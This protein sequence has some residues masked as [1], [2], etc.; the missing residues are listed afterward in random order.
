[1][2]IDL[3]SIKILIQHPKYRKKVQWWALTV[4]IIGLTLGLCF[5]FVV[6]PNY[7]KYKVSNAKFRLLTQKTKKLDQTKKQLNNNTKKVEENKQL[8]SHYNAL[9]EDYIKY[10]YKWFINDKKY[11][12]LKFTNIVYTHEVRLNKKERVLKRKEKKEFLK[13]RL[14]LDIIGSYE[15]I[16]RYINYINNLPILFNTELLSIKSEENSK[17]LTLSLIIQIYFVE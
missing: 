8:L 6:S 11:Q 2:N 5:K 7:N 3:A 9:N 10:I 12:T 13:S 17:K 15:Q 14:K 4:S 1:M 16:G